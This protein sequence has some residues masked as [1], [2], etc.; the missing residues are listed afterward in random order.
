MH[1]DWRLGGFFY[2]QMG[3]QHCWGVHATNSTAKQHCHRS[4]QA[5]VRLIDML[6]AAIL[7]PY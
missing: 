4:A 5:Y 1:Y 7:L 6:T 2:L 3:W